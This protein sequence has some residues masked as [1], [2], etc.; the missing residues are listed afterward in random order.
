[1]N[2]DTIKELLW[3]GENSSR[4]KEAARVLTMLDTNLLWNQDSG[5]YFFLK[6]LWNHLTN[7]VLFRQPVGRFTTLG[8]DKMNEIFMNE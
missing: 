7:T 8:P 3:R 1:M 2:K 4:E 5:M 6:G